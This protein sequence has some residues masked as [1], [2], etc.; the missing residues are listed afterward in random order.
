MMAGLDVC[1]MTDEERTK[2][3]DYAHRIHDDPDAPE[4][5]TLLAVAL[6]E[7]TERYV[8]A[9]HLLEQRAAA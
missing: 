6:L 1:M 9:E 8:Q 2:A 7:A 3:L 5:L 4:R